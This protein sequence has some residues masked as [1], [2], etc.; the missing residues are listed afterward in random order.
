MATSRVLEVS[1]IPTS[2][3]A[4][5]RTRRDDSNAANS[6]NYRTEGNSSESLT[7]YEWWIKGYYWD[8]V[9]GESVEA[10][11]EYS[12]HHTHIIILGAI[13]EYNLAPEAR[14]G[15]KNLSQ[16]FKALGPRFFTEVPALI[17]QGKV[18]A[19]ET[20]TEGLENATAAFVK[21]LQEGGAEEFGKPVVIVAKELRVLK[22]YF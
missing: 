9:G 8:N 12:R 4:T 20:F 17:A 10:A 19:R 6:I 11:I 18:A 5:R 16:V 14:Y 7:N 2:I 1:T 15:V 13:S 21:V 3:T 22:F